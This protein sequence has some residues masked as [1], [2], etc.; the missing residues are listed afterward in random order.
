V[1]V[2]E[3]L[4]Q[5]ELNTEPNSSNQIL[6]D[7]VACGKEKHCYMDA[8][9]GLFKCHRCGDSGDFNKFLKFYGVSDPQQEVLTRFHELSIRRLI[10]SPPIMGYLQD[11]GFNEESIDRFRYGYSDE[12][13]YAKLRGE[14]DDE[15][16]R[17]AGLLSKK[18]GYE[19]FS[20]HI[21]IPY[22]RGSRYITLQGRALNNESK[23]YAFAHGLD[24]DL[25]HYEDL[26]KKGPV[27]L[28]EGA[29]KRDRLAQEDINAVSIPG[30]N[31]WKKHLEELN[32]CED[33]FICLDADAAN[34]QGKRPGQ[35]A[36][37]QIAKSL[38]K[39]TIIYLPLPENQKKIGV[40]DFLDEYGVEALWKCQQ[41]KYELGKPQKSDNLAIIVAEWREKVESH[42]GPLGYTLG[43]KR[44]DSWLEGLQPGALYF[45]AGSPHTGKSTLLEDCAVRTYRF[46][47]DVEIDY[48]SNDDS[49]F[50]AISR[51]VAKLGRLKIADTRKPMLAFADDPDRMRRYE[52]A[53]NKLSSMSDRMKIRDRSHNVSLERMK[54]DLLRWREANPTKKKA[55]FLDAFTKTKTMR[56]GEMRDEMGLS[57]YK[58][59]LL[60]DIAQQVHVPVIV[61]HEVPKLGGRRPNSW[62]LR[63]SN[64]LEYD[65]DVIWLTYQEA[66]VKGLNYTDLKIVYTNADGQEEV[67]PVLE[68]IVA[69]DKM[70]GTPRKTDL[71][72]IVKEE[73]GFKELPDDLYHKMLRCVW[74]SEK[75]SWNQ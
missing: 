57:I 11:R 75:N 39:C 60:K 58:S 9:T 68:V 24:L 54:E 40:D 65:A 3:R 30:A 20:D 48:Y 50:M 10:Q 21:I 31:A 42:E 43:H 17:E 18:N 4:E 33:L 74:E 56:D 55:I 71:F 26:Y 28:T 29:F 67:A 46:H 41:V 1:S 44:L 13:V 62:N 8:E 52:R 16:L 45:I 6:L 38:R 49:L 19:V 25:Y 66:H 14:F 59:S 32:L 69:K 64:T 15:R 53:V 12:K 72:Q 2:V 51:L 35:D 36:A 7:C 27:I 34:E 61:T 37:E 73:T 63:G 70:C 47:E 5:L 22:M 23:R